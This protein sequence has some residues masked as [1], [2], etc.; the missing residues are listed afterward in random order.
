MQII[1]KTVHRKPH[2]QKYMNTLTNTK[3]TDKNCLFVTKS[4]SA[5]SVD[6]AKRFLPS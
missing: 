2:S 3:L 4:T 5:M 6:K 1:R